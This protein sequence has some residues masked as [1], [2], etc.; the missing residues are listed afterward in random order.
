[1]TVAMKGLTVLASAM[2]LAACPLP[3]QTVDR[4]YLDDGRIF[5]GFISEQIPGR[6]ITVSTP[7][8]DRTL[9]WKNVV[10]TE[11]LGLANVKHGIREV[12]TLRSGES[13]SGRIAIQNIGKDMVMILPDG[14][15]RTIAQA[16]VDVISSEAVPG[17][18][19]VW[20]LAPLLDRLVLT[21][22][23]TVE[24]FI[25]SRKMGES[26]SLLQK[27]RFRAQ[28]YPLSEI[29]RYQK[30]RNGEAG[31]KEED[32][33]GVTYDGKALRIAEADAHYDEVRVDGNGSPLSVAGKICTVE[34]SGPEPEVSLYKVKYDYG[35]GEN[36]D[37]A[38][39][40]SSSD[41]SLSWAVRKSRSGKNTVIELN[42]KKY[43]IYYLALDGLD[44]GVL[45]EFYR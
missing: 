22:G 29:E 24:G 8:G 31:Q 12:V 2:M 45:I 42:V 34:V 27:N 1:M 33:P 4:V 11:K 37:P 39:I 7:S 26:V 25:V 18:G 16:D 35:D 20:E 10:K 3:G 6:E 38:Y 32:G 19:S 28:T 9:E 40:F 30:V 43:G 13:I 15:R 14:T 44:K 5:D 17:D 23:R 41:E 36:T 21:D